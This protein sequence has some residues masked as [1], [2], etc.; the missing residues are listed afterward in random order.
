MGWNVRMVDVFMI[1]YIN[2]R[3][4]RLAL[5]E[6]TLKKPHFLV[7]SLRTCSH[8]RAHALKERRN[9]FGCNFCQRRIYHYIIAIL[10]LYYLYIISILLWL[11]FG[12]GKTDFRCYR[13]WFSV[14]HA[15]TI[16]QS[17]TDCQSVRHRLSVSQT[18]IF[19][20]CRIKK[21]AK[22]RG[23]QHWIYLCFLRVIH[24]T[25]CSFLQCNS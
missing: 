23:F 5:R 16:G 1:C 21:R 19:S 4:L 14:T 17:R 15:P 8:P 24:A 13:D 20:L 7:S 12:V 3:E 10:S 18:P 22:L 9:K 25:N 2:G 11:I 6:G